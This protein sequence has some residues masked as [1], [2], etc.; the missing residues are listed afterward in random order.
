MIRF[1]QK[2][3]ELLKAS[4]SLVRI[5]SALHDLEHGHVAAMLRPRDVAGGPPVSWY[6]NQ[7]RGYAAGVMGEL[8]KHAGMR[9]G[10]AAAWVSKRLG[11]T[12]RAVKPG[13]VISWRQHALNSKSNADL[14]DAYR[15]FAWVARIDISVHGGFM[16]MTAMA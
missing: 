9:R 12:G 5:R 15:T 11:A 10:E 4:R 1:V 6:Q 2:H 14:H 8:M 13:T 7:L 16:A 3:P